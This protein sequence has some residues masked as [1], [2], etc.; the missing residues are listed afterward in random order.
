ME[1]NLEQHLEDRRKN[2]PMVGV[3]CT[4]SKDLIWD[5]KPDSITTAVHK[6]AF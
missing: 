5:A 2:L 3:L 6:M 1:A 4:D